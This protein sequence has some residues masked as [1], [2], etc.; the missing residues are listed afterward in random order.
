MNKKICLLTVVSLLS[1]LSSFSLFSEEHQ[2]H[3]ENQPSELVLDH[4]KKW[5][6]DDSLHLGMTK[7]KHEIEANLD[8]IHY[9]QFTTEQYQAL[10]VK[11]DNHLHFI[12][13][14]CKLAPAAD[15]QL[16]V[17]LARV[18]GG[19]DKM[20]HAANKKQGAVD[21]IRAL[22]LYPEFF[23]DSHWQALNH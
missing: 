4:G 3:H 17:L 2:H 11:L 21:I 23:A 15:A 13:E 16:H 22:Q 12:F 9:Q 8:A 10:A 20:K 7:I 14:N 5:S 18:M 6:I 1:G 19:I